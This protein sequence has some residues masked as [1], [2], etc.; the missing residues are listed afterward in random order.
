MEEWQVIDVICTDDV[1]RRELLW[2]RAK[3]K[4]DAEVVA[5]L[6]GVDPE[7]VDRMREVERSVGAEDDDRARR[8]AYGRAWDE[9]FQRHA[10]RLAEG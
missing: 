7:L 10:A 6:E 5:L 8:A 9:C 3:Q 2:L 1:A 4:G